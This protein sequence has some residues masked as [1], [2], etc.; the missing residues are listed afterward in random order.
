VDAGFPRK[1]W[2]KQRS[3]ARA[4]SRFGALT[5]IP[6]QALAAMAME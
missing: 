6:Y 3:K 4:P 1:I 2:L 5:A